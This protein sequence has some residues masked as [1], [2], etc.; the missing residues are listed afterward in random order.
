MSDG[1]EE[2]NCRMQLCYYVLELKPYLIRSLI[3]EDKS[4]WLGRNLWN[5]K[6]LVI[7]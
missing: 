5:L 3:N 1:Q 4:T 7:N 2:I 6:M